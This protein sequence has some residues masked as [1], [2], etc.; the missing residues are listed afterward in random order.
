MKEENQENV[1]EKKPKKAPKRFKKVTVI[2]LITLNFIFCLFLAY[3]LNETFLSNGS[4]NR[5]VAQIAFDKKNVEKKPND[6]ALRVQLG[7]AYYTNGDVDKAIE[8][9]KHA[10][11][12]DKKY[13]PGYLNL[14]IA[15]ESLDK[16][17][18]ALEMATKVTKLS[19][20]DYKGYFLK[21]KVYRKLKMYD[22][23]SKELEKANGM[24]PGNVDVIYEIGYLAETQKSYNSAKEIYQDALSYDPMFKPAID[25]IKR[26]S[27]KIKK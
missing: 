22:K 1:L 18:K 8:Q 24:S 17:E 23:S 11:T 27:K 13:Y 3:F 5:L 4:D 2:G 6:P 26:V 16:N 10:V 9:Y 20:K 25:G 19:P 15:Y 12:I 7:F 14:A 21:G